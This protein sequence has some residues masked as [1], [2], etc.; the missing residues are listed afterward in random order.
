MCVYVRYEGLCVA[1]VYEC[2]NV[3]LKIKNTL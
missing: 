3:L 1:C 2:L